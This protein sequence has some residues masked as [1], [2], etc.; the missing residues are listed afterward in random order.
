MTTAIVLPDAV[1][2]ADRRA[3]TA[4]G[5]AGITMQKR[6]GDGATPPGLLP[7]RRVLYR[8]DRL[9]EPPRPPLPPG[10]S[11][12]RDGWCDDPEHAD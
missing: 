7:L 12:P 11:G 10:P 1:M 8:A 9:P 3:R 5:A 6:E 4:V 2:W